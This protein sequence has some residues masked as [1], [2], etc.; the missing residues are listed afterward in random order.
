MLAPV[1]VEEPDLDGVGITGGEAHVIPPR[2]LPLRTWK[3]EG[4]GGELLTSS[5]LTP[6]RFT[7]PMRA[8]FNARATRLVS[9]LM[10]TVAPFL[11]AVP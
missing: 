10:V 4:H 2:A 5:T 7:P 3:R 9:R 11:S 8:R 1:G 6:A